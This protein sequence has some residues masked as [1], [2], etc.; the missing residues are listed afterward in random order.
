VNKLRWNWKVE[1][2]GKWKEIKR[3][4]RRKFTKN[5]TKFAFALSCVKTFDYDL[6]CYIHQKSGW[7]W[8]AWN[9]AE[10]HVTLSYKLET[11]SQWHHACCAEIHALKLLNYCSVQRAYI[12]KLSSR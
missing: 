7:S 10:N 3:T 8:C 9:D 5:M 2:T 12:D 4:P 11:T 6:S 1:S